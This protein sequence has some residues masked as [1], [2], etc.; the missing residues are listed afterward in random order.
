[1]TSISTWALA[2]PANIPNIINNA[3]EYALMEAYAEGFEL[4]AAR[5]DF[6]IDLE[7]VARLWGHGSVVRSWLL[8]LAASAFARDP[9][10]QA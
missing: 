7:K 2:V 9:D 1:M 4:L 6:N 10:S 3:I 5:K 8:E